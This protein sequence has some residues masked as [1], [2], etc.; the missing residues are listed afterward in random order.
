MSRPL[1]KKTFTR[2]FA[3]SII[4]TW[5]RVEGT[6][7]KKWTDTQF[8]F[9]PFIIFEKGELGVSCYMDEQGI[10]WMKQE[11]VSKAMSDA[12]FISKVEKEFGGAF[13]SIS[14]KY[15][16]KTTLSHPELVAFLDELEQFWSWFEAGWWLWETQPEERQ[17]LVIPQSLLEL[18]SATQ[19][20]VP[21]SDTLVRNSLAALFPTVK[22]YVDVLTVS[23]IK[24][25][26]PVSR[27]LVQ[28]RLQHYFIVG[29]EVLL[30]IAKSDIETK[31]QIQFEKSVP[32]NDTECTGTVGYRGIARGIVRIVSGVR[33]MDRVYEG[34][35]LIAPM[36]LPDIL[37][38]M[39]KAAAFVTDEGGIMC[40][41]AIIAREMKKPCVI[42][43]KFATRIFKDGD[44]I[45]VNANT[46]VV[47]KL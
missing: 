26:Q 38:A 4:E 25:A 9:Q 28:K 6:T 46:G 33:T 44:V 17:G 37:P 45:E 39:K 23:E 47:R 42:G 15:L 7:Q 5:S 18:R 40:H 43:T 10:A 29:G 34:D 12:S 11:L 32:T 41:A 35:I 14:E 19:N 16:S 27:T 13:Q 21:L 24:A 30:D 20:L 1:Y 3:L 31:Y 22:E 2:D 36:T 8:P